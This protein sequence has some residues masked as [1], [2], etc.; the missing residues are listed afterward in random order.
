MLVMAMQGM[1]S[2]NLT[3]Y[4]GGGFEPPPLHS[5]EA[6]RIGRLACCISPRKK[7]LRLQEPTTDSLPWERR[8]VIML[9]F[10]G[11][12]SSYEN[13]PL[14]LIPTAGASTGHHASIRGGRQ[15]L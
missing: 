15:Q 1:G 7:S 4:T 10:M 13:L 9:A 8:P 3:Y 11:E 12:G 5:E 6:W 14:S 2:E